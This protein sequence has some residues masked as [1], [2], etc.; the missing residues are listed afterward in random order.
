MLLGLLELEE[1]VWPHIFNNSKV[2]QTAV[3]RA[4]G[5]A[6]ASRSAILVS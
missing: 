2:L 5:R 3:C 1:I 6:Q 4:G